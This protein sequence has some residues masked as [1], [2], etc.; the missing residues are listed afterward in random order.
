MT[1]FTVTPLTVVDVN[2]MKVPAAITKLCIDGGFGKIDNILVVAFQA[3]TV[4]ALFVRYIKIAG[5]VTG[6]NT[7]KVRPVRCMATTAKPL[8]D[9]TMKMFFPLQIFFYVGKRWR[10]ELVIV[11]T[12]E[13]GTFFII[14]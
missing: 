12:A 13:T 2:I 7:G 9:R 10:A 5:V 1:G 14:S 11:V 4:A 6:Q 3:K 8:F